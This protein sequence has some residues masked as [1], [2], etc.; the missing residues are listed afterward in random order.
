[1]SQRVNL[2]SEHILRVFLS[3]NMGLNRIKSALLK[4]KCV[5]KYIKVDTQVGNYI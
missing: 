3:T 2:C 4:N 1:M 5:L